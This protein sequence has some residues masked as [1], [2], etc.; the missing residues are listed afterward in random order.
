MNMQVLAD[1]QGLTP[2]TRCSLEDL[3]SKQEEFKMSVT[4]RAIGHDTVELQVEQR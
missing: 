3:L 2:D 1:H 4:M